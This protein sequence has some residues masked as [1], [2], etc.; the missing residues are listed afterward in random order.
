[1]DQLSL[2]NAGYIAA[3]QFNELYLVA[4][5]SCNRYAIPDRSFPFQYTNLVIEFEAIVTAYVL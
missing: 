5:T 1:M 2:A 4:D 3:I